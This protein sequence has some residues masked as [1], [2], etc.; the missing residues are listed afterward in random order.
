MPY[1]PLGILKEPPK[2]EPKPAPVQAKS[3][4]NLETGMSHGEAPR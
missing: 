4:M 1:Y 2:P 3:A